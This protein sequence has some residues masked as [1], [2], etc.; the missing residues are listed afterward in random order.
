MGTP[1]SLAGKAR[2]CNG[3]D[4]TGTPLVSKFKK[5]KIKK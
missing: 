3:D 5:D 4:K 2:V 1:A